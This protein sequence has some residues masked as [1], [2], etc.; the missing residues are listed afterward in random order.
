[1]SSRARRTIADLKRRQQEAEAKV[2]AVTKQRIIDIVATTDG[3]HGASAKQIKAKLRPMCPSDPDF[4]AALEEAVAK[5]WLVKSGCQ[6]RPGK[7]H[8]KQK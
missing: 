6:Y 2:K 8:K 1:M 5:K 4:N 7:R 3:P